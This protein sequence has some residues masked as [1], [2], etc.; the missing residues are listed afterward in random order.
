MENSILKLKIIDL[1]ELATASMLVMDKPPTNGAS[2]GCC[3]V[4]YGFAQGCCPQK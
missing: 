4:V 2:I 1:T 3:A